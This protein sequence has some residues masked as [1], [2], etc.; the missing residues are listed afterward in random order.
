MPNLSGW[1]YW[2]WINY[3]DPTGSHTSALWP[4]D[5]ATA[6]TR[7]GLRPR[8][9]RTAVAGDPD[10]DVVRPRLGA[11]SLRVPRRSGR[12]R[13]PTVIFVPVA[14]HYPHGYCARVTGARITSR[15]GATHLDVV[16]G[17]ASATVTVEVTVGA[18]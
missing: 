4:P 18:C 13:Q 6:A 5:A 12:S 15:P 16:N 2:Q 11:F 3:D 8:P 17:T 9:T 7:S 10:I 1:I 14:T